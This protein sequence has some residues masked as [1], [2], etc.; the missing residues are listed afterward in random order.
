MITNCKY[1]APFALPTSYERLNCLHMDRRLRSTR[2]RNSYSC[3][4]CTRKC[5]S[6]S[7][8]TRHQN[9]AHRPL[10]PL[11]DDDG[12]EE[13][14]SYNRHRYLTGEVGLFLSLPYF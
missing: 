7:G 14:F 3:P 12:D 4:D 5:S 10:T 8:L 11:P 9:A 2:L 6:A 13:N 1:A